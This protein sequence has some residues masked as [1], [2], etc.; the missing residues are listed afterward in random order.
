MINAGATSRIPKQPQ[1]IAHGREARSLGAP[2][3]PVARY[4]HGIIDHH[5]CGWPMMPGLSVETR[6]RTRRGDT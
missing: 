3:H 6:R 4:E 2:A 5:E 1:T